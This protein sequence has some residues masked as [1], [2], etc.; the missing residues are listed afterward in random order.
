MGYYCNKEIAS[1][2]EPSEIALA[3]NPNFVVFSS[4]GNTANR[5][6]MKGSIEVLDTYSFVEQE[7]D[8]RD[9]YSFKI[10]EKQS[11]AVYSFHG[12]YDKKKVSDTSIYLPNRVSKEAVYCHKEKLSS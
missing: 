3:N 6:K 7:W 5:Q 12:T 8:A 10:V 9:N 4:K 1:V 2:V 11:G